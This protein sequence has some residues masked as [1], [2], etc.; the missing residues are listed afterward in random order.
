MKRLLL[1]ILLLAACN[2]DPPIVEGDVIDKR[3]EPAHW[4]G[5]YD[6]IPMVRTECHSTYVNGQT[7]TS[8]GPQTFMQPIWEDQHEWIN[9]RYRLKLEVCEVKD[10]KNKCR[11]SW[12]T[13]TESEYH[14]YSI[15]NHYPDPQ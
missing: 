14:D 15:G 10:G 13:V 9:D 5:G 2:S 3:F 7:Q 4:E 6:Y 8:C 1:I 12:R 11:S